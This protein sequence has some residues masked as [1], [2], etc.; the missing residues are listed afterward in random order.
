[1]RRDLYERRPVPAALR[2]QPPRRALPRAVGLARLG[3]GVPLVGRHRT[4]GLR[5]ARQYL[6]RPHGGAARRGGGVARR[7]LRKRLPL[8]HAHAGGIDPHRHASVGRHAQ[9][10]QAGLVG[11]QV[12]E[13]RRQGDAR[14]R[15]EERVHDHLALER[16]LG[17]RGAVEKLVELDRFGADE[18]KDVVAGGA[19][20]D[21]GHAER[22]PA[23]SEQHSAGRLQPALE[24]VHEADEVGHELGARTAVDVGRRADL[25]KVAL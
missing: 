4:D 10:A 3:R 25:L 5:R 13:V 11:D 9:G 8:E 15:A 12:A 1:M 18:D 22:T 20:V 7:A 17:R 24:A 16:A 2:R 21:L 6:R 19:T 23:G 14:D